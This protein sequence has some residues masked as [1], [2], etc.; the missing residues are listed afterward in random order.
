MMSLFSIFR[1]DQLER[2]FRPYTFF[3]KKDRQTRGV[4]DPTRMKSH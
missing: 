3:R 1:L 4:D 2:H